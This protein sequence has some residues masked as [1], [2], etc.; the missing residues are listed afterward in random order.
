MVLGTQWVKTE[1][2]TDYS[3]AEEYTE[4]YGAAMDKWMIERSRKLGLDPN[5]YVMDQFG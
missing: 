4:R 2:R 1:D 5:V 3:K